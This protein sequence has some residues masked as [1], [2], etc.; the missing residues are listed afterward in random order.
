MASCALAICYRASWNR[1]MHLQTQPF[2]SLDSKIRRQS[3]LTRKLDGKRTLDVL[4]SSN[5]GVV[6]QRQSSGNHLTLRGLT[7]EEHERAGRGYMSK[8]VN[9]I[10]TYTQTRTPPITH[11]P[12][13]PVKPPLASAP[14][15]IAP[16]SLNHTSNSPR[17]ITSP[18]LSNSPCLPSQN[19][20]LFPQLSWPIGLGQV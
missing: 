11:Q 1:G 10:L 3:S 12:H 2:R 19:S 6:A 15:L 17:P 4:S 5:S 18:P 8:K 16:P 20:F 13:V 9:I 7:A 14:S